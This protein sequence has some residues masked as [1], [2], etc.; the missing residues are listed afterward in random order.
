[1]KIYTTY[2]REIEGLD[3][4]GDIP[5]SYTASCNQKE[6]ERSDSKE[7]RYQHYH[8]CIKGEKETRHFI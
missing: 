2:G 8:H 6:Y 3:I 5:L 4:N 7:D 1:M